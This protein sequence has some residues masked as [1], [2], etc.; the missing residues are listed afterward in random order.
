MKDEKTKALEAQAARD[1][2][3]ARKI[4]EAHKD[5]QA[6]KIAADAAA[7]NLQNVKHQWG[8]RS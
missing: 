4:S 6:A 1:M 3:E 7:A 8:R 5:R 2:D